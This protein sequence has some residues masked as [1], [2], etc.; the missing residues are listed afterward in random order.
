MNKVCIVI[1]N[2]NNFGDTIEC[3]ESLLK[4]SY[5]DFQIFVVDNSLDNTSID[6]LSNWASNNNYS[7]INTAFNDLVFPLHCKPLDHTVITDVEFNNSKHI[8]DNKLTIIRAENNG[9][10]AANNIVLR[11]LLKEEKSPSLVW[12]LNNDTVVAND[13]LSNLLAFFQGKIDTRC[14]L[15][16]KLRYYNKPDVIQAVAGHYNKWLGKHFHIGNNERDLGQYDN[17]QFGK[18]DYIVGASIFLPKIFIEEA[19]LMSEEYFLYFEELDWVENGIKHG[20]TLAHLPNALVYH[21]EGA[22][23]TNNSSEGNDTSFAEYYSIANRVRYIKK[24]HPLCLFTVLFGVGWAV[25]KRLFRGQFKLVK[26][27]VV[28]IICILFSLKST[29]IKYERK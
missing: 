12:I 21:K 11:Y 13:T 9:F 18:M 26:M 4:S 7:G 6:H 3:L 14:L 20:F 15:G 25:L 2:Y 22:S 1:V 16:A 29:T 23:I 17:Y 8:F 27:L 24:W 5:S 28:S 19:G 10:A